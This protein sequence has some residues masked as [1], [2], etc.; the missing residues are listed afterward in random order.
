MAAATGGDI[1]A[2]VIG[3]VRLGV[4]SGPGWPQTSDFLQRFSRDRSGV[5]LS[6]LE[7][8]GGMLWRDLRDGRVDALLAPTGNG[9]AGLKALDLGCAEWVVL[10]GTGHPLAGIAPVA[11]ADLEGERI[12]LTGH[13]DDAACDKAVIAVLT[14]LGVTARLVSGA[15]WPASHAAIASN[16]VV[17]L[18]TAP[19]A[20]PPGVIARRLEPRRTLSFE[21]L[22]RD[23]VASPALAGL[24]DAAAAHV[25]RR[26]SARMLAAAA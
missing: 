7:G 18:T 4:A 25:Q 17:A 16:D 2:G 9:A 6:V 13:R 10:V 1:Q 12:A 11:A 21:L 8:Y 26:R 24:V 3:S 19:E 22:W 15:P 20:L 23:E 14:E 5:E